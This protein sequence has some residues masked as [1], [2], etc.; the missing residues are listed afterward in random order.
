MILAYQ[1][2]LGGP[3]GCSL[4]SSTWRVPREVI[5]AREHGTRVRGDLV[6][7]RVVVLNWDLFVSCGMLGGNVSLCGSNAVV[8]STV[9]QFTYPRP[10]VTISFR[11]VQ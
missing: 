2:A 1:D 6:R 7:I 10:N 11:S 9:R 4:T 3:S 8:C 5:I